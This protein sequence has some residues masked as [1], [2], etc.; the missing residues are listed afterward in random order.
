MKTQKLDLK[1]FLY[2]F[3]DFFESYQPNLTHSFSLICILVNSLQ[4]LSFLIKMNGLSY[5]EP[6]LSFFSEILYYANIANVI[7]LYESEN[8]RIAL[9]FIIQIVMYMSFIV[10]IVLIV[11]KKIMNFSWKSRKIIVFLQGFC[12]I[13]NIYNWV[14]LIPILDFYVDLIDNKEKLSFSTNL[15]VIILSVFFIIFNAFLAFF[16]LWG[17]RSHKFIEKGLL[18]LKFTV[19]EV[20]IM[21]IRVLLPTIFP[22]FTGKATYIIDFL[23]IAIEVLSLYNSSI[24][25]SISDRF[26][27]RCYFSI[28]LTSFIVSLGFLFMN[29][30]NVINQRN[31]FYVLMISLLY[32]SKFAIK[33]FMKS[34]KVLFQAEF[35]E[36]LK[37]LTSCLGNFYDLFLNKQTES[38]SYFYFT[39]LF[40]RHIQL[41][42]SKGCPLTIEE[43][44]T[45]EKNPL[46]QQNL[47]LNEFVSRTFLHTIKHKH[48][49]ISNEFEPLLLKYGSFITFH[50]QNP[51]HAFLDLE[52][53]FSIN[54]NPSF[55]FKAI[56]KS[57]EKSLK[58]YILEYDI[59]SKAKFLSE[60]KEMDVITFSSMHK[61]K[62]KL[63]KNFISLLKEKKAFWELYRDGFPSYDELFQRIDRMNTKVFEMQN[64][65]QKTVK[66]S[67]NSLAYKIFP[68][69]YLSIL[70]CVFMNHL[71]EGVK[72]E[73]EI[74]K[75]RKR[76]AT[77]HK[78]LL[79]STSFF[80]D[81]VLFVQA[82][83][84]DCEG[85]LLES[86]KTQ[87]LAD[88]FHYS[89]EEIKGFKTIKDLMPK[90]LKD[91]HPQF[92]EWYINKPR[93]SKTQEKA[94][95]ESFGVDKYGY[96][97]PLKIYP[98][99]CFDYSNDFVLQSAIIKPRSQLQGMLF[100]KNG[101]IHGFSKC[102]M[103]VLDQELAGFDIK[104]LNLLNI[105]CL[106]P[107]LQEILEKNKAFVDLSMVKIRNKYG[108]LYIP[109]NLKEILEVLKFKAKD[110]EEMRSH[111]SYASSRSQRTEKSQKS[112]KNE[113]NSTNVNSN[114]N[115]SK[116][117]S[118]FFQTTTNMSEDFRHIL[119][120]KYQE[121]NLSNYDIIKEMTDLKESKRYKL[122][123]DLYFYS[124]SISD[125]SNLQYSHLHIQ[126]F[127]L[128]LPKKLNNNA[129]F[130]VKSQSY[131][132]TID[133]DPTLIADS[134]IK[135]G[136][137][138]M[139]PI[140]IPE[141]REP[142]LELKDTS[143]SPSEPNFKF[144]APNQK[145][146]DPIP[147]EG[148]NRLFTTD[149]DNNDMKG[150]VAYTANNLIVPVKIVKND[151][152]ANS[153]NDLASSN[154]EKLGGKKEEDSMVESSNSNKNNTEIAD[155]AGLAGKTS[156][157]KIYE[158][159]DI[160]SQ[161]S[162]LSSLKKTF[163]IFNM[164]NIIQKN[165]PNSLYLMFFSRVFEIL[166]IMIFCIYV[167][168]MSNQYIFSYYIPLE[169][170]LLNFSNIF[171]AF[172]LSTSILFQTDLSKAN[173]SSLS[174]GS[175][176]FNIFQLNMQEAYNTFQNNIETE[177]RKPTTHQYQEYAK[178]TQINVTNLM[179]PNYSDMEFLAFLDKITELEHEIQ[180]LDYNILDNMESEYFI[181][182]FLS[183]NNKIEELASFIW[184]EFDDTNHTIFEGIKIVL[185][186]FVIAVFMMKLFEF[187]QMEVFYKHLL[188]IVNIFLRTNQSESLTEILITNETN[189]QILDDSD[190]FLYLNYA[191][192]LLNRKTA[193]ITEE[194]NINHSN[195]T[196]KSHDKKYKKSKN[197]HISSIKRNNMRAL[198][199]TPRFLFSSISYI[200]VFCFLFFNYFYCSIV[201][202][203]IVQLINV[204]NFFQ[205]LFTLPSGIITEKLLI[206]REK[207]F[208][209]QFSTQINR[210]QRVFDLYNKL[211]YNTVDLTNTNM[212]LPKYTLFAQTDIN[213]PLFSNIINGNICKVLYNSSYIIDEELP[214]CESIYD[215]AFTK[216]ILSV[217]DVFTNAI[218]LNAE[219]L[220][221]NNFNISNEML[222]FLHDELVAADIAAIAYINQA[223]IIFYQNLESYYKDNMLKQQQNLQIMLIV[224]TIFIGGGFI[225]IIWRYLIFCKRLYRNITLT[226]SMIPYDRLIN[227]E[228]TVFLIKKFG[229]D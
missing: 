176:Y 220:D 99:H 174:Q 100:D 211:S 184:V 159:K 75:L 146:L 41:C 12:F 204:S 229:K 221:P 111:R 222:S 190:K 77:L 149:P 64:Y 224:T 97:F 15:Y 123:F 207:L 215:G 180:D 88:F 213:N 172:A 195:N 125:S 35:V 216:G 104:D 181:T 58:R 69:K 166:L 73:D 192:L 11:L 212:Q 191:E 44:M 53:A 94:R 31:L 63:N 227:D 50:N 226:L 24:N 130:E 151:I 33:C 87:K 122:N 36:N 10:F 140:N 108:F 19:L 154:E 102:F 95:I 182:N 43:F 21:I 39:G 208:I 91:S 34:E 86:S 90:I 59:S 217:S 66:I 200:L 67:Q 178:S 147:V 137:I 183:F 218:K 135:S 150:I 148:N 7:K 26:L 81:N 23:I 9:F 79:N 210:K 167:L 219:I 13:I 186:L 38:L 214:V 4:I 47:L 138:N 37:N 170:G 109:N 185:I 1:D 193:K 76:E 126:K 72:I 107:N 153:L 155:K 120:K 133:Q 171:N 228:Q 161:S 3:I 30:T 114:K 169:A 132:E 92:I 5:W 141:F 106:I 29:Y 16:I 118:R 112:I 173:Y 45:F 70:S 163:A 196:H 158:L 143:L 145:F 85:I 2:E 197:P 18:R 115:T 8:L 98:G 83:F 6:K 80:E 194:D 225:L 206:I 117:M 116:F 20:V 136:F 55:F 162:S 121:N 134:E 198:S 144:S 68:L 61:I 139:P 27:N 46:W 40:R 82:S 209:N 205:N 25:F 119:I 188:R 54:K 65:L 157:E 56:V 101:G 187:Y 52:K 202:D 71:N 223:L 129:S 49:R 89:L 156:N 60:S 14:L 57:L 203:Q 127:S 164:M 177:R 96:I 17:N 93:T 124:H 110:E 179:I 113:K 199:R 74:E 131:M 84:L 152:N 22:L 48:T 62:K 42:K 142:Q 128:Y 32:A 175:T 78:E 103:E 201:N 189:K 51:I 160:S 105:Y 165:I 28:L 168:I